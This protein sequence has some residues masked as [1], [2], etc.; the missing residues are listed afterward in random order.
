M[1]KAFG[2]ALRAEETRP[3]GGIVRQAA[4]CAF[5]ERHLPGLFDELFAQGLFLVLL[6]APTGLLLL[7]RCGRR[8]GHVD[9]GSLG[10]ED[11][12]GGLRILGCLGAF[13]R[14]GAW[15]SRTALLEALV[16]R[17]GDTLDL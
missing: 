8:N 1:E 11:D 5:R 6:A 4:D 10:F 2:S 16:F 17:G 7:L 14:V 12:L 15:R 13:R 3:Q 9:L